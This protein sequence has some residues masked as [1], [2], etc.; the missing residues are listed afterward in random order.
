MNVNVLPSLH[1]LITFLAVAALSVIFIPTS[2]SAVTAQ[3]TEAVTTNTKNWITLEG[4][5]VTLMAPPEFE[6]GSAEDLLAIL[7]S[8]GNIMGEEFAGI[9]ELALQSPDL[10]KLFAYAPI[11]VED[12]VLTNLNITGTPTSL[13]LPM[14]SILQLLSD[15]FPSSVEILDSKVIELGDYNEAGKFIIDM[16]VLGIAQRLTMYIYHIDDQLYALTFTTSRDA[17]EDFSPIFEEMASTF[18]VISP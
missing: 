2:F 13:R 3:D 18:E 15:S 14:A 4:N 7:D 11:L 10:Y 8:A 12:G 1:S 9:I 5:G 16:E 6:G 17:Y